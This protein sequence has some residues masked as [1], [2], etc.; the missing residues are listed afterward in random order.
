MSAQLVNADGE[1]RTTQQS[2]TR[3]VRDLV[4][5]NFGNALEWYDWNIYTV[6]APVFSVQIF[7]TENP[8]S[9]LLATLAVFAV[10]FIA[11]PIGG[12]LFGAYADKVGRKK[13]LFV[14]MLITACG[15]LAIAVTPTFEA[16][17]IVASIVL[18]VA[19]LAQGLAHGGEMGTAATYLIER[20]PSHRRA[21]FGS[22][23]WVSVVVGTMIATLVG[24][25]INGLLSE[26]QVHDWGWRIAFGLGGILGLYALYLRRMIT[27]TESYK[28]VAQSNN[29]SLPTRSEAGKLA[30]AATGNDVESPD[31]IFNYWKGLLVIFGVSAGGS[32][33]FYT[34]LIYFPNHAQM[35]YNM[36]PTQTLSASLMAQLIFLFAILLAGLLGDRIGRKPMVITFGALFIVLPFPVEMMLDGSFATFMITQVIVLLAIATLFGVNAAVWAEALPTHVRAKGVASILSLA[37]AIF[38]GT[39]PYLITWF[40][41]NGQYNL[42]LVYLMVIATLTLLTGI[43]MREGKKQS[44]SG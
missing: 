35:A 13:S 42:Y 3:R 1:D 19:R 25:A 22:T 21:L 30:T 10:G 8:T 4:A 34:W 15:S 6:F 31:S 38:G 40:S 23:S 2:H 32:L 44:L 29:E 17:G 26:T 37:T 43:L 27:E 14:A 7:R 20:A 18:L 12:I 39:A 33:M 36:S 28:Q 41:D 16:V 24:L 11:R 9:A 5:V